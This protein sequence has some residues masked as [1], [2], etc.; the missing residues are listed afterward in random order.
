MS[1]KSINPKE[2]FNSIQH[3][4]SQIVVSQPGNLV[5][6]SG[7]V[8]WDENANIVREN[9]LEKQ[10]RKA[11]NN[12]QVAIASAGGSMENIAMLRI[13]IVDYKTEDGSIISNVLKETFG[14]ES[15]PASTW[16]SVKGLA[17]KAFMIE[18]EAQAVV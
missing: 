2:L 17:N 11:M 3:G 12:L 9:D 7:Q 4:F 8:A 5:H 10:M 15:P 14:T 1:K 16:I 6:I 18:I 13:Y